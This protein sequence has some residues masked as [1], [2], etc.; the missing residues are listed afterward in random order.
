MLGLALVGMVLI[1]A[2]SAQQETNN[3]NAPVEKASVEPSNLSLDNLTTSE[4]N[5]PDQGPDIFTKVKH[6]SDVIET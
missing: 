3:Y 4:R 1:P 2:V 5:L 6:D